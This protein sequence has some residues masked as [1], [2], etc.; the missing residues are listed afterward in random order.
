VRGSVAATR[1]ALD[2]GRI[3]S[4]PVPEMAP[5]IYESGHEP[6]RRRTL[7]VIA[8]SAAH[9]EAVRAELADAWYVVGC[10]TTE[11][12]IAARSIRFDLVLVL[13]PS[14][15][16]ALAPLLDAE[17]GLVPDALAYAPTPELA[18]WAIER[19]LASLERSPRRA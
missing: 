8:D 13:G 7:L 3:R 16:G 10:A 6:G 2:A 5:L 18:R 17:V 12:W 11:V 4:N 19:A 14:A 1:V 9:T 15:T